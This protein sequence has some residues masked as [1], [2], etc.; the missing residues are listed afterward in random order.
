MGEDLKREQEELM[1][2]VIARDLKEIGRDT[3][4]IEQDTK[5]VEQLENKLADLRDKH[6]VKVVVDG[7]PYEVPYGRETTVKQIIQ[8]ALD[9]SGNSGR[10]AAEWQMKFDGK[11]LDENDKI[12]PMHLP[13][14]AVLFLSLRA[15][16]LG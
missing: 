1:E 3:K 16:T 11:V 8:E 15:G 10:S 13:E 5:E 12:E 14:G 2:T 6:F 7:Q 9:L 4:Q